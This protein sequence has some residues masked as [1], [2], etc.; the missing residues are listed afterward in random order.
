M[1]VM[2]RRQIAVYV[3]WSSNSMVNMIV[4]FITD[5]H[6]LNVLAEVINHILIHNVHMALTSV[7]VVTGG[8]DFI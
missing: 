4:V 2:T 6:A 5:L 8:S 3:F 7:A 1:A